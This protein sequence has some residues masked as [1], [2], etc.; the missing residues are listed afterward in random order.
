MNVRRRYSRLLRNVSRHTNY[1]TNGL[2]RMNASPRTSR[3]TNGLN[4][5]LCDLHYPMSGK[6]LM[7]A[8]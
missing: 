8:S 7:H 4:C 2:S 1:L 5:C 6:D 3:L